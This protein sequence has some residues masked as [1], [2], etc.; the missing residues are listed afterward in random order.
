MQVLREH[1]LYAKLRKCSFYQEEIH[2]LGHI[3]SKDGIVVYPEKIEAI[4]ELSMP[5]NVM[6]VRSFMGLA[7][8][9][10][11]FITGFSRIAYPITSYKG[12]RRSFGGQ[13]IVRED[14]SN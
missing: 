12:R 9:Y 2:Y 5:K 8:Y 3:I 6:K 13:R 7:G 10:R 11:R 14:S 4:I 1:Q